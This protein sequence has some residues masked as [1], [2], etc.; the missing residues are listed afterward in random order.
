M[1][2]KIAVVSIMLNE[3]KFLRR[4]YESSKEADYQILLDTGSSDNSITVA[5]ELG[6]TVHEQVISP[7]RFDV[8]RNHLLDL[9]PDDVDFIINLDADELIQPGWR[10]GFENVPD[11][12]NRIRYDYCWNWKQR[13]YLPDGSDDIEKTMNTPENEGLVYRGDKITRRFSHRWKNPVHEVGC[14]VEGLEEVQ[15]F[16]DAIKIVHFADDSKSRGSY[17]PLLIMA[18]EEDPLNDRNTYYLGREFMYVGRK[19]ESVAMFKR[20]LA[21]P[22]ALWDAER[23][24]SMRYIGQM[25]PNESEHWF[26]RACAEYP[27]GREPWVELAQYYHNNFNWVG[28]FFAAGKALSL[29][30]KG[31]AYLTEASAWGWLPHD[32]HALA[33]YHLNK[34]DVAIESGKNAINLAPDDE[35]LKNN[36]FFYK[37]KNAKVDIVIP[38]KSYIEG[39]TLLISQLQLDTSVARIVVV[40]DGEDAYRLLYDLPTDIIKI[41]M[42]ASIGNIHKMWSLGMQI[43]GTKNHIAFINDDISLAENCITNMLDVMLKDETIGLISP[44]YATQPSPH[45]DVDYEVFSVSGSRYDGYGGFAGFCFM[46]ARDL[47]P[48]W[49]FNTN[50]KW[51]GGDNLLVGWVTQVMKRKAIVTHKAKCIHEDHTTFYSDPPPD[52]ANQRERDKLTYNKF[53]DSVDES[54]SYSAY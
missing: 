13:F 1:N 26:L 42:P 41:C 22:T 47:V 7:W 43:L 37:K 52:W 29:T 23:A 28:C 31:D 10:A 9:I 51:L 49:Q 25:V 21:L 44:N 32:L 45:D 2:I 18:I 46:I 54:R 8:A 12:V 16:T 39:L 36:L 15:S 24:F 38:F 20:H 33:A 5:R 19:E 3:E 34:I 53:N 27:H 48:F 17:L 11:N 4:W 50:L 35:R 40:A 14:T 30:N 6:I